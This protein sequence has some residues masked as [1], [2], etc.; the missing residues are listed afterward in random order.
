[1]TITETTFGPKE[2]LAVKR[3]IPIADITNKQMY[4]E[5]GAKLGAFMQEQGIA[6]TGPWTVMYFTWDQEAGRTDIGIAFPVSATVNAA[7]LEANELHIVSV[8]ETN[9]SMIELHGSYDGL[10]K[11]HSEMMTYR[12][13]HRQTTD[14]SVIGV[15]EYNVG[16][17]QDTNSENWITTIY[18]F[19]N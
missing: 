12:S 10:G 5:A 9:A 8:P 15:E 14:L 6:P 7:A 16:P 11:A 3:S 2:Y 1:M 17:M 18:Y 19:H 4:D 13:E